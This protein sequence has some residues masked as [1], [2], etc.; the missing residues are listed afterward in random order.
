M[1]GVG[2]VGAWVRG[3]CEANF[4]IGHMGRMGP[5]CFAWIKK[6]RSG[7]SPNFGVGET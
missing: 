6:K 1:G 5:E 3:R 2:T 7:R 4:G